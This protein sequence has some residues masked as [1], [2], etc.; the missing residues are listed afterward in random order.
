MSPGCS[1]RCPQRISFPSGKAISAEDSGPYSACMQT[2]N[3]TGSSAA[4]SV[5]PQDRAHRR[6]VATGDFQRQRRKIINTG[7]DLA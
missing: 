1:V 3:H 2:D 5:A 4:V 6:A 7:S